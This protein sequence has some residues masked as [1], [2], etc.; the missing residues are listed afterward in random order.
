MK[1]RAITESDAEIAG[2][3]VRRLL[4]E[5]APDRADAFEPDGF[6]E[7]ARRL[8]AEGN[9]TWGFMALDEGE[10][11]AV[12]AGGVFGVITELYVVPERRSQGVA[13]PLID[14]ARAF[15][16][17]RGWTHVEVTAP[18]LPKWRRTVDFYLGQG[19]TEVGVR[20]KRGL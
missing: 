9:R 12:Y 5:L 19:F 20:L 13:P 6:T 11:A 10:C 3:L 15:G 2:E 8:L 17:R 7:R 1:V 16:E 18:P 4:V 14:A